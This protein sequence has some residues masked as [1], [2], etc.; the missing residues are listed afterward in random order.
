MLCHTINLMIVSTY[1]L[2]NY[3]IDFDTTSL[4]FSLLISCKL[5]CSLDLSFLIMKMFQIAIWHYIPNLIKIEYV[6]YHC[7]AW[8]IWIQGMICSEFTF[9]MIVCL[10]FPNFYFPNV[11]TNTSMQMLTINWE[12]RFQFLKVSPTIVELY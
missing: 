10:M 1:D 12:T 6:M 2:G 4:F 8:Y 5:S 3:V 9:V 11:L 7:D